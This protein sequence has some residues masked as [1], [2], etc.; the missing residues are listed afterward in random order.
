[1]NIKTINQEHQIKIKRIKTTNKNHEINVN[2]IE[3]INQDHW[4]KKKK[5]K[6][7]E[8]STSKVK[9][10]NI[11]T[12]DQKYQFKI[13]RIKTIDQDHKPRPWNR[14]KKHWDHWPRS[15]NWDQEV[16]NRELLIPRVE[17]MRIRTIKQKH[18]IE[19][20]WIKTMNCWHQEL[21]TWI[22]KSSN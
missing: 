2:K 20:M 17:N 6:N 8:L 18:Q 7:C 19:V 22:W 16:Q 9:N 12:I 3:T 13:K 5:D 10:M 21:K 15:S 4:I 11:K 1:M 14:N